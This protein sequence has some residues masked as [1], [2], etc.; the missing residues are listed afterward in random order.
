L[1][2]C[3]QL[4]INRA[5]LYNNPAISQDYMNKSS[6]EREAFKA[7]LEEAVIVPYLLS[8]QTPIDKPIHEIQEE[9]FARWQ[10]LCQEVRTHCIR[11]SWNDKTNTSLTENQLARR[12][13]KFALGAAGN[14]IDAYV[15]DL[16]MD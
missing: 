10:E 14:D 16:R 9:A 12:F 1:I 3:Q 6:Q 4:I 2:N 15:A 11:L 8:E 7:L 5:F 13:H